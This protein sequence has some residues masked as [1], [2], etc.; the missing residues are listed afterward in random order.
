[1][2]NAENAKAIIYKYKNSAN[3]LRWSLKPVFIKHL[4]EHN[5]SDRFIYLDN[6]LFFYSDFQFLFDL[7]ADHSFLLTPH[8]YKS[9]PQSDQNWF[10]ANFRVGLFNAGFI[11]A[12]K[13]ALKT[14]QWW[15]NCCEYRCEK[16]T[17][18]GLFDD[19]KYLDLVPVIDKNAHIVRHEGCNVAGWNTEV[20]RREIINSQILINGEFPIVFIHFNE[21]TIREVINGK[22]KILFNY[23]RTYE[24]ILK[25][26]KPDL[27]EKDLLFEEP[28][29]DK[30]KYQVWKILTEFGI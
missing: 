19:Q 21:T 23:Y 25:K 30:L 5:I 22:D 4:L 10:E 2:K 15:A 20:C 1:L 28:L 17:F 8:H 14:L 13:A 3:K 16:N 9:D 26:Y 12:N 27:Q 6:D 11:G 18:R 24:E 29:L 7:L